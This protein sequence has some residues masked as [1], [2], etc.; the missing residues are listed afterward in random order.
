MMRE[1]LSIIVY[2]V[3]E[4]WKNPL[5]S[6]KSKHFYRVKSTTQFQAALR[7][8]WR[9]KYGGRAPIRGPVRIELLCIMPRPKYMMWK[10]KPTPRAPHIIRPDT[11]NLT[12]NVK[13]ALK[14][15]AWAD[16]CLVYD[17][18]TRKFIASG[19]EAPHIILKVWED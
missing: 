12:K 16:D 7:E 18:H 3:P 10:K 11:D 15:V 1:L 14:Q 5:Y 17:E 13:D 2:L 9:I 6:G 4:P 19:G 8:A